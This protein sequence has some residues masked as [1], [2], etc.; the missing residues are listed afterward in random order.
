MKKI[1][2]FLLAIILLT[3]NIWTVSADALNSE[4]SMEEIEA[5]ADK[6]NAEI[7][8]IEDTENVIELES[9]EEYEALLKEL[10]QSQAITD[11]G[12]DTPLAV[13]SNLGGTKT[14]VERF[15]KTNV[16][17]F[18]VILHSEIVFSYVRFQGIP[19]INEIK[20]VSSNL[21]GISFFTWTQ[22]YYE[23]SVK[24]SRY[25]DVNVYGRYKVSASIKGLPLGMQTRLIHNM[26]F[27]DGYKY[28]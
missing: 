15:P 18:P 21:P 4:P 27:I 1:C 3:S 11:V 10:S 9:L 8:P 14:V 28:F 13:R 25:L 23:A 20:Y 12:Y 22:E 26:L 24:D 17:N 16:W 5:I 7:Y 2:G 6:Y 19:R